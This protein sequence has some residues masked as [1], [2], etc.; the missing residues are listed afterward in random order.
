MYLSVS[1]EAIVMEAAAFDLQALLMD[2]RKLTAMPRTQRM[3]YVCRPVAGRC[4][5]LLLWLLLLFL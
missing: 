2:K 4:L 3:G 5:S 1:P